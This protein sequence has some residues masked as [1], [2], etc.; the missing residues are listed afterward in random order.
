MSERR[1]DVWIND[2]EHQDFAEEERHAENPLK[3][4][5]Q[6]TRRRV[7]WCCRVRVRLCGLAVCAVATGLS[8]QGG[9]I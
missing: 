5:V 1:F 3:Y 2:G 4:E 6:G 9:A 8:G 7:F